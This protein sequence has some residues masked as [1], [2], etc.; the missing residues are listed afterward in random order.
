MPKSDELQPRI[1]I[2]SS[3]GVTRASYAMLPFALK[4]VYKYLL[5]IPGKDK[6]GLER[7]ISYFAGWPWDVG[8]EDEPREDIVGNRN[9]RDE[10]EL[11]AAGSLKKLLVIRPA[12]LTDG[13]CK[14]RYRASQTDFG[15]WTVSRADVTHFIEDVALN[16]W[17]EF[18]N[19][20]IFIAY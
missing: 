16:K 5:A 9:W 2:V 13:D 18:E 3:A 6:N 19:K 8:L 14:T 10:P 1:V 4:P 12:L 11:P 20:G 17:D 7:L 15:G